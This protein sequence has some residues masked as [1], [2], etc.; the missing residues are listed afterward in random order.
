MARPAKFW[1]PFA[2][3]M[4]QNKRLEALTL[5]KKTAV[6]LYAFLALGVLLLT[7]SASAASRCC[8]P[9]HHAPIRCH[10]HSPLRGYNDACSNCFRE[11]ELSPPYLP[12]VK[13]RR[14]GA[15]SA[16]LAA[17]SVHPGD[18]LANPTVFSSPSGLIRAKVFC[19][20]RSYRI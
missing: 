6:I 11:N 5:A 10:H 8:T 18:R 13:S 2:T 12:E 4:D 3:G 16:T 19:L 9:V 14:S 7:G 20:T 15:L 17:L 1:E